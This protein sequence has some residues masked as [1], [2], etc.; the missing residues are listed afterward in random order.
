[1]HVN[2]AAGE[3]LVV[4]CEIN[5]FSVPAVVDTGAQMSVM[6][7]ACAR[8]CH[9]GGL[10]D[11]RFQGTVVGVGKSDILGRLSALPLRIGPIHFRSRVSVLRAS[12]VDLLLGMDLL[13]HFQSEINVRDRWMKL[14]VGRRTYKVHFARMPSFADLAPAATPEPAEKTKCNKNEAPKQSKLRNDSPKRTPFT[15]AAKRAHQSENSASNWLAS[16]AT[17]TT[18]A[19]TTATGGAVKSAVPPPPIAG[20]SLLH[21]IMLCNRYGGAG[22]AVL[23]GGYAS[24][25]STPAA[26]VTSL[27]VLATE[28]KQED[29]DGE[30]DDD[31]GDHSA[32]DDGPVS[33]EGI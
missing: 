5:G 17:A 22:A 14:R 6:S 9:L 19:G 11:T 29:K 30:E 20:N 10:M 1:M 32:A 13:G 3:P 27:S 24:G 23:R 8:R 7:E 12:S 28:A 4:Q 18:S 25:A 2:V 26:A 15:V 33:L 21:R 31:S 16:T